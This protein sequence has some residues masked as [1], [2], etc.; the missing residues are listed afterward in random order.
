MRGR[1]ASARGLSL[2][3]LLVVVGILLLLATLLGPNLKAY[4]AETRLLGAGRVFKSHF[5]LARSVATRLNVQTAMKLEERE[6]GVYY[7]VFADGN[8]NGVLS[9]DIARGVDWKV[10]GPIRLDAGVSGV[11]VGILPGTPAPPPDSGPLD[12]Q[13]PVR[14]GRSNMVS[15][16]PLGTA[17]PGTFY[18]AGQYTQAAVRVTGGSAR[19]RLMIYRGG[20]WIER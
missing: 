13:D 4:A 6:N 3:E 5:I 12:A 16:S 2:V 14:F 9:R 19:V 10:R 15:F 7:T 11:R 8:H 20:R 1:W 17:T 18:L